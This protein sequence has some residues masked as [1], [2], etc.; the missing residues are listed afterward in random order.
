MLASS[1]ASIL[2]HN[3]SLVGRSQRPT[4]GGDGTVLSARG[5]VFDPGGVLL[6]SNPCASGQAPH[7][8]SA[9]Y[10]MT[11]DSKPVSSGLVGRSI[12]LW[13]FNLALQVCEEVGPR[14]GIMPLG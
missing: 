5:I 6:L 13:A 10:H 1:L 9:Q 11:V 7:R 14:V 3:S 12:R 2:N 8:P 4:R